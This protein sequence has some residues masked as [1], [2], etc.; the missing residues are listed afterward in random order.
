M[1]KDKQSSTRIKSCFTFCTSQR[2]MARK[3]DTQVAGTWILFPVFVPTTHKKSS[4]QAKTKKE[5]KE[6]KGSVG[7][8]NICVVGDH[9]KLANHAKDNAPIPMKCQV[10]S[11]HPGYASQIIWP[12]FRTIILCTKHAK[13][14][15]LV[16]L[17]SQHAS[18]SIILCT[19][20]EE[21]NAPTLRTK[22]RK[23][24]TIWCTTAL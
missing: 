9:A 17:T 6:N 1:R 21:D 11:L 7:I 12:V 5:T 3:K 15:A 23:Y 16:F 24:S 10:T 22:Y 18:G 8:A 20:H 4:A 13:D 2:N 14:N 19:K